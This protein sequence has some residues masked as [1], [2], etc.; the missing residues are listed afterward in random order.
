MGRFFGR[1]ELNKG[2]PAGS[3]GFFVEHEVDADDCTDV[4]ELV[5]EVAFE[6]LERQ[7]TH[8]EPAVAVHKPRMLAS[9]YAMTATCNSRVLLGG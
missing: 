8:E 9:Q 2:E 3:A 5:F 6:N 7:V 1:A 4:A